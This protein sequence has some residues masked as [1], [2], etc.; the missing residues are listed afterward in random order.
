MCV[1]NT[2]SMHGHKH[3]GIHMNTKQTSST[4][5]QQPRVVGCK[6]QRSIPLINRVAIMYCNVNVTV[7]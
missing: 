3:E 2:S 4:A 1:G 6:R 7:M 5:S